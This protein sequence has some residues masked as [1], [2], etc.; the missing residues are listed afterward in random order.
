MGAPPREEDCL[1]RANIGTRVLLLVIDN[2]HTLDISDISISKTHGPPTNSW[3][4]LAA[5][6]TF[7]IPPLRDGAGAA[8]TPSRRLPRGPGTRL[9]VMRGRQSGVLRRANTRPARAGF[10]GM[11]AAAKTGC[12]RRGFSAQSNSLFHKDNLS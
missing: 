2:D 4:A 1:F 3:Q 10:P 8:R 9:K 12:A 5:D 6:V 11:P 7:T